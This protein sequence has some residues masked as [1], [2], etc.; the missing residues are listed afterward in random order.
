MN[1]RGFLC[2]ICGA[3]IRE[4]IL[5]GATQLKCRYCGGTVLIPSS[6]E[7]SYHTLGVVKKCANHLNTPSV[8]TC[9]SCGRAFCSRC[10]H[11]VFGLEGRQYYCPECVI[12]KLG[13]RRVLG[14]GASVVGIVLLVLC[15]MLL[16]SIPD[17]TTVFGLAGVIVGGGFCLLSSGLYEILHRPTWTTIRD[18]QQAGAGRCPFCGAFY[19]Y[20]YGAVSEDGSVK[21]QNCGKTFPLTTDAMPDS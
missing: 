12:E 10:L 17:Q 21:C 18:E 16:S 13:E 1:E 7:S 9:Q 8:D 15:V 20:R 11:I 6:Y 19:L 4:M 2:P 14:K 5:D 3:P